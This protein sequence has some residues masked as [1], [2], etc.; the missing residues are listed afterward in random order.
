MRRRPTQALSLLL[1]ATSV[2]AT[3]APGSPPSVFEMRRSVASSVASYYRSTAFTPPRAS[4]GAR[5][6]V[7]PRCMLGVASN[8]GGWSATNPRILFHRRVPT[9]STITRTLATSID[10]S[11]ANTST[12]STDGED[13]Y[14]TLQS[15]SAQLR[16]YDDLYYNT[17]QPA[18]SDD[19]YDALARREAELCE[20]YPQLV[21]RLEEESGLGKQATRW[22]GRVGYVVVEGQDDEES[23]SASTANKRK[24]SN[25]SKTT[26]AGRARGKLEHLATAPM[27]SLDNAMN[28]D[29][30]VKW[31]NRVRKLLLSDMGEGGTTMSVDILAEPKM[32]GLSLS[33]RYELESSD[34]QHR[35]YKFKWGASRGDGT[36]GEDVTEAVLPLL[37]TS[38]GR[39]AVIP[40]EFVVETSSLS[41]DGPPPVVEVRGEVVLPKTT[42]AKLQAAHD[43]AAAVAAAAE[44]GMEDSGGGASK[45][46]SECSDNAKIPTLP[47]RFANARNA[48]SGILLRSKEDTNE[49]EAANTKMLR[50]YLRFY[51]Y[52]VTTGDASTAQLFGSDGE[53]MRQVLQARGFHVPEPTIRM[54]L[55][56][57]DENEVEDGELGGLFEY[58]QRLMD[59]RGLDEVKSKT[60]N[61]QQL[62]HDVDGAVY[63]VSSSA[64]R[65]RLGS[66][67]RYPRWAI[68]HKFP[69]QAAVTNLQGVE[70]QVGRTG[71]LTPVA[72]LEPVDIG[73]VS[74]SR[75]SLHN[76]WFAAQL[77]CPGG[78][79]D[80]DAEPR[81]RQGTDVVVG[82][83]GDVIPQVLRLVP[84]RENT[85]E[86]ASE[87][88]ISLE[89]PSNCPACGSVTVFDISDRVGPKA[90]AEENDVAVSENSQRESGQVLRCSAPQLLCPPR[91]VG[92]LTHAFSRSGLDVTGLSE[93]RLQ[94]LVDEGLIQVPAD[95][96]RLA[97]GDLEPIASLPGWGPKS[98][99]K[100]ATIAKDVASR[101]VTLSRFIYSLGI[102]HI[103]VHTS[104][105]IASAYGSADAFLTDINKASS[106]QSDDGDADGNEESPFVGLTG[107]DGVKGIGPVMIDA[108]T[109]F[110]RNDVLVQA[111]KD[112]E[113]VITVLD[114]PTTTRGAT[115]SSSREDLPFS[116]LTIVFTGVVPGMSRSEAQQLAIEL[117]AKKTPGSISKSTDLVV[118]GEKGGKKAQ[119]AK[120][121]EIRVID[122]NEF[123]E[124]VNGQNTSR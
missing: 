110:S 105:L 61:E 103:G 118:E 83:A 36:V 100:L 84:S 76:F 17:G 65:E 9:R 112:L 21:K 28:D 109:S 93:A 20:E 19:E 86:V 66:S 26:P 116:G 49:E 37:S 120:E 96:F 52:D 40:S 82:R 107:E 45:E 54:T 85:D 50:S 53:A 5:K 46:P 7:R 43:E 101:G 119:K 111:A 57:D 51:A 31:M 3:G 23:S 42:F 104:K 38:G 91:A 95:L 33:L 1:V 67:F 113:E 80:C 74:V 122:A 10:E 90:K 8:S 11:D 102:R 115:S 71:A 2:T 87:N 22:G 44:A 81:V 47:V 12:G 124:I 97:N 30:V 88:W 60:S 106:A 79:D 16:Q 48:A 59:M 13:V 25:K 32:D 72:I 123:L 56:I 63:K 18:V 58:H 62:D 98:S 78:G 114:E 64:L 4:R 94:Q 39:E 6:A 89:P 15:L 34:S 29:E 24:K 68:A 41:S 77:L 73:G 121:M 92:A 70:V 14:A 75:A 117:G 69:I 27:K 55:N 35:V 99:E 108:L